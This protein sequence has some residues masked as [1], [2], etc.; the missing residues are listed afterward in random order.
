MKR[1]CGKWFFD[2]SELF[3]ECDKDSCCKHT[4]CDVNIDLYECGSLLA[5]DHVVCLFVSV[6]M[7]VCAYI[8]VCVCLR[9][10]VWYQIRVPV[11]TTL[12]VKPH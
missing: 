8:Y 9:L 5:P 6:Y 11:K 7:L 10:C 12:C 1:H 3:I 4:T 2:V